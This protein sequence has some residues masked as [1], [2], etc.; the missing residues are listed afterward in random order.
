MLKINPHLQPWQEIVGILRSITEENEEL[1]VIV[2]KYVLYLP[3][4]LKKELRKHIGK[5]IGI[6]RTD[7]P[8]K[9]YLIAEGIK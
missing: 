4:Y 1:K 7:I 5:R 6:L 2:G 9:E 8:G 3:L